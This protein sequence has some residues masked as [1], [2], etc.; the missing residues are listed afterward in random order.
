MENASDTWVCTRGITYV[1]D[2]HAHIVRSLQRLAKHPDTEGTKGDQDFS[3]NKTE[4]LSANSI[5][6]F[7]L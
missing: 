1:R 4:Q 5:S 3:H 6:A 2:I 7:K